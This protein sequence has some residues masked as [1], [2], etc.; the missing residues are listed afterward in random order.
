[1][2]KFHQIILRKFLLLFISLF[3]IIGGVVYYWIYQY[4]LESSKQALI[5]NVELLS[6]IINEDSNL[7]MLAKNIKNNLHMRLTVIDANG[8]VI[9]ESDTDKSKMEN[10]RYRKEILQ[11]DKEVFGYIVRHSHT[12]DKDL[13]YVA[14]K[15]LLGKNTIYIRLANTIKGIQAEILNLGIKVFAILFLFFV[16]LLTISYK[17]NLQIQSETNKIAAFLK[18]LTKKDKPTYITSRYSKEFA[19]ITALLTKVSQILAKKEKQKAK[20]TKRLEEANRQKDDII[21]AISH[22]FKNPI[23][24]VNGYSQTLLDDEDINPDIRKKFL[25]K[26]HSNGIKLTN[27]IDTLRLSMKLDGGHQNI[28]TKTVKL[29]DLIDECYK[30]L[31]LSYPYKELIVYGDKESKIEVDEALFSIVVCNLIENAFK[32]SEDEVVVNINKNSLEVIDTG[33]GISSKDLENITKKFYRANK[34]TWNNSL[35]LGL[36]LVNNIT[37]LHHFKLLITSK[38]NKGSTFKIVFYNSKM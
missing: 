31:K 33:I 37:K 16:I 26:I 36:F 19:L 10:H 25:T 38:R 32:Y 11:S 20:Y 21:S 14:K 8:V 24:V 12:L 9:A 28:K 27:L 23:A 6:N 7:D 4:Y 3:I 34:N 5:Q 1:M 17:I 15:I 2:L 18:A 30:S 13:Q 22:E 35:G 29:Y